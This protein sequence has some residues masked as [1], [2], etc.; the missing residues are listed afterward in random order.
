MSKNL[1][2]RARKFIESPVPPGFDYVPDSITELFIKEYAATGT[3]DLDPERKELFQICVMESR[4][5]IAD[6]QG[7][8]KDFF[9]ESSDIL[10]AIATELE[11]KTKPWWK[12]W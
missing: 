11:N 7:A 1:Q 12:F 6:K 4:N 8:V 10:Y 3:L 5:A 9:Q 2:Q